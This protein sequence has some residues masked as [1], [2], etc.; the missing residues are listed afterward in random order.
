MGLFKDTWNS[1]FRDFTLSGVPSSGRHEP[2]KQ[3]IRGLGDLIEQLV[4]SGGVASQ[5][6]DSTAAGIA[7]TSNG[8]LFLV[9]GSGE[10]FATLWKN[11]SGS[12][13]DQGVSLPSS[14]FVQAADGKAN[15]ALDPERPIIET[16]GQ[17][18]G[19]FDPDGRYGGGAALYL[20]ISAQYFRSS[21][22][23]EAGI[24]TPTNAD[25]GG[26]MA[27][28]AKIAISGPADTTMRVI[29]NYANLRYELLA[30]LESIPPDR[31]ITI[32]F[33]VVGQ[34]RIKG[35][36]GFQWIAPDA[37]H[38]F[39]L[40][41]AVVENGQLLIPQFYTLLNGEAGFSGFFPE[42]GAFYF[43]RGIQPDT[44][45][46]RRYIA[47]KTL[48][49]ISGGTYEAAV[50]FVDGLAAPLDDGY[51]QI[52]L[53]TCTGGY[54]SSEYFQ[55][56]GDQGRPPAVDQSP[57]GLDA[58]ALTVRDGN[59]TVVPFTDPALLALGVTRGFTNPATTGTDRSVYFGTPLRPKMGQQGMV[60]FFAQIADGTGNFD[61]PRLFLRIGNSA[62]VSSGNVKMIRRISAASAEFVGWIG[63]A[64]GTVGNLIIG[65]DKNGVDSYRVIVSPSPIISAIRRR[66][67]SAALR[68][69]A[70]TLPMATRCS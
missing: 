2:L 66:N 48:K 40:G 11:S 51:K 46:A 30:F 41:F 17:G 70:P 23:A 1:V 49:D 25:V 6:Y 14:A 47:D 67:G 61:N 33:F 9:K 45:I 64:T 56:V 53:A 62:V 36:N 21:S 5:V 58:D 16:G 39:P 34:N 18:V 13:V 27:N 24:L 8:N 55:I 38:I 32:G 65:F 35:L 50:H 63:D 12:A 37:N 69:S 59:A 4:V 31:Y 57:F 3:D 26:R 15:T 28:F 60:R 44:S 52:T 10:V 29:F 54:V 42:N 22:M 19:V 20:P 43:E 7:A 68:R